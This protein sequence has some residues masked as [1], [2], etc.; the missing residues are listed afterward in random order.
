MWNLANKITLLRIFLMPLVILLLY[1]EGP[2]TCCFAVFF[3]VLASL[4]DWADGYVAR[5]EKIVT[6]LG[7]FLDPL[8]DKVLICSVLIM[9]SALG[10]V[11]AWIVIVMVCRELIVT[12]LRAVAVDVGVVLAADKFG[13]MKTVFQIFAILPIMLHY[14]LFGV[15]LTQIGQVLLYMALLL[16]VYSGFNYCYGFFRSS[17]SR[18]AV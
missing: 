5:R 2:V 15:D 8:A 7:K 1:F 18:T 13:K 11:P 17:A 3:F 4:T 9:F 12:G 14:P 16:A 6:N 10:W